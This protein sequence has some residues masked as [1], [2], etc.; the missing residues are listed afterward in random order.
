MNA[1]IN[2][3]LAALTCALAPWLLLAACEG[4]A[5][6]G[7]ADTDVDTD[8]DTDSDTDADTRPVL[9]AGDPIAVLGTAD[10]AY[11]IAPI[12]SPTEGLPPLPDLVP[13]HTPTL[14]GQALP[15]AATPILELDKVRHYTG[16]SESELAAALR[17]HGMVRG[18][19]RSELMAQALQGI[20]ESHNHP[21]V[22][23]TAD[24]LFN[25]FHNFFDNLL[26]GVEL[27]VL[28]PRLLALL[29]AV[30][31]E[32]AKRYN[33]L[34]DGPTRAAA[35]DVVAYLQVAHTLMDPR[36][37][38]IAEVRDEVDAELERIYP[39]AQGQSVG[40]CASPIF[41]RPAYSTAGDCGDNAEQECG[42]E[43][44]GCCPC[45]SACMLDEHT[46]CPERYCEDYSQYKPRGHY[47]YSTP[48]KRYFRSV[49]WLGR[50]TFRNRSDQSTRGAVVL[51]DSVKAARVDLGGE[52]PVPAA[53]VWRGAFRI[54]GTFVGSPDDLSIAEVDAAV[55]GALDPGFVLSDLDD[56]AKLEAVHAAIG[57]LRDPA[58]L[59]G[60]LS[61]VA[62][63]GQDTKGLRLLGQI[64]LPDSYALSR[65]VYAHVGPSAA[66]EHWPQHADG[67]GHL[68]VTA[69]SDPAALDLDQVACVCRS[70]FNAQHWD[71]CRDMP[72]GLDVAAVLGNPHAQDLSTAAWG[73]RAHYSEI[74]SELSAEF[75]AYGPE[76]WGIALAWTWLHALQ[77]LLAPVD[78]GAPAFMRT[79]AWAEKTTETGLAS[80]AEL[81]HDTILYAKQSYTGDVDADTDIDT[82]TDYD[83]D[84]LEPQPEA[85]GRL[86]S[87]AR[88]LGT[89]AEE[90]DLFQGEAA[91][92][93]DYLEELA[94]V[95][96]RAVT[97]SIK[98]L[99]GEPLS[100][101][102]IGWIQGISGFK[103]GYLENHLLEALGLTDADHEPDPERL[104]TTI[105]ADVHTS[106][107]RESKA[108][109]GALEVG[110]GY[111]DYV[112]VL[113]QLPDGEHWGVAVGPAFNYHEF[114]HSLQDRLTDEQWREML[115]DGEDP[116][117]PWWGE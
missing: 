59:S 57:E 92:L 80:W 113:H 43:T 77:G 29:A 67:C 101:A 53:A 58:I 49:M 110:S 23:L 81:R 8:S 5:D 7:D 56:G 61:A 103:I 102:D 117:W 76:R 70:A 3:I 13:E 38:L 36:A 47:T 104:K 25:T 111:L 75:A 41:D 108:G 60:F 65:L 98:E 37:P 20:A 105:I 69:A 97:V 62:D 94:E 27:R 54:I 52:S 40:F 84:Y 64:F 63:L 83:F 68:G 32:A 71:V 45:S 91:L 18:T 34:P 11:E 2:R 114:L 4:S 33:A 48:L 17:Q 100:S 6:G 96:E 115:E 15:D 109:T 99:Q 22:L 16:L 10:L 55:T 93:G 39:D 21:G 35:L 82:D 1:E 42:C 28:R 72:S 44:D 86:A 116:G 95:Y 88:R 112:V 19:S 73:D 51:L 30:K 87:A 74:L 31:T 12:S 46:S 66:A 85:Y 50:M 9:P 90:T 26:L 107:W 106:Q 79:D 78:P 89:L 14:A 24:A